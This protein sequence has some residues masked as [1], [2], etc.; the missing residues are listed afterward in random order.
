MT[1]R[2]RADARTADLGTFEL[3]ICEFA[4]GG[5][6]IAHVAIDA[7]SRAVL[8][9]LTVPGD[10]VL[11]RVQKLAGAPRGQVLRLLHPSADRVDPPCPFFAQCGGCDWMHLS[12]QAQRVGREAIVR[13]ALSHSLRDGATV[14]RHDS[15]RQLAWRRR[16]RVGLQASGGRVIAGLRASRSHRLVQVDRCCVLEPA[17]DQA[18]AALAGWLQ[19]STGFGEALIQPGHHGLPALVLRWSGDLPGQLFAQAAERV[20]QGLWAGA[21]IWI[22]QAREPAVVGDPRGWMIGADGLELRTSPGGFMQAFGD[23]NA[24]LAAR[25]AAHLPPRQATVELFCGSGNI[26]VMVARSTDQL[27]AVESERRAVAE[28]QRNLAERGL[29]AKVTE[30]DANG[31]SIGAGVRAV[32]LDPPRTGAPEASARIA[33]SRARRVVMVSCDPATLARDVSTLLAA[34]FELRELEVLEMFPHTS[35]ME[36]VAV[37]DRVN[38]AAAGREGS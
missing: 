29:R 13:N 2:R 17:I 27:A 37:L 9:P 21:E 1:S 24:L 8:V 16:V 36:A 11:A 25:A 33:C 22:D 35:H 6:G 10:V 28:A 3:S 31:C 30:G 34:G 38:L 32:L 5:E 7:A 26:T 15:P 23:M 14:L 18:R 20:D 19:G 4:K 12:V